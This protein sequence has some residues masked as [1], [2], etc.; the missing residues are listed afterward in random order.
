M[1]EQSVVEQIFYAEPT[2]VGI[3]GA[4]LLHGEGPF[5][6]VCTY[7]FVFFSFFFEQCLFTLYNTRQANSYVIRATAL[8]FIF[9]SGVLWR[10]F[11]GNYEWGFMYFLH[12]FM[13]GTK[14]YNKGGA[15]Y[16]NFREGQLM[17]VECNKHRWP[18]STYTFDA[19]PL[20]KAFY[21]SLAEVSTSFYPRTDKFK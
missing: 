11:L 12:R 5:C 16:H 2:F 3:A 7:T 8:H 18:T 14:T 17:K 9:S 20:T 13:R 1:S 10:F 19:D 21:G 15:L 4:A 6:G